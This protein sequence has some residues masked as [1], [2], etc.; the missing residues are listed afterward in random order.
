MTNWNP[1]APAT[2]GLQF[3]PDAVGADTLNAV[4]RASVIR[5]ASTVTET[6]ETAELFTPGGNPTNEGFAIIDVYPQNQGQVRTGQQTVQYLPN[7]DIQRVGWVRNP[8]NATTLLWDNINEDPAGSWTTDSIYEPS[9]SVLAQYRCNVASIG[10]SLGS[11]RVTNVAV[12]LRVFGGA[13]TVALGHTP[14][15]IVTAGQAT[16]YNAG[17]GSARLVTVNFGEFCP[18]TGAPWTQADIRAFDGDAFVQINRADLSTGY[19]SPQV[20]ALAL[21]VEMYDEKRVA[22]AV[23]RPDANDTTGFSFATV[24]TGASGWAKA[25]GTTYDLVIRQGRRDDATNT[26]DPLRMSWPWLE[27]TLPSGTGLLG[28]TMVTLHASGM[29]N[30]APALNTRRVHHLVLTGGMFTGP[31]TSVDGS[32]YA[33][34]VAVAPTATQ[35]LVP[36]AAS[37]FGAVNLQVQIPADVNSTQTLT[38][39]IKRNSDNATMGA[40]VTFD[41]GDVTRNGVEMRNGW[42]SIQRSLGAPATLASGIAY[43]VEV[44]GGSNWRVG[45]VGG[46]STRAA[47][48]YG[49]AAQYSTYLGDTGAWDMP[50]TLASVPAGISY[51]NAQVL[52]QTLAPTGATQCGSMDAVPY[53]RLNWA[54]SS[55]GGQFSAYEVE[56]YDNTSGWQ[57]IAV[58]RS[59]AVTSMDDHEARLGVASSYRVRQVRADGVASLWTGGVGHVVAEPSPPADACGLWFTTNERPDLNLAYLDVYDGGKAVR[60]FT[61]L[62]APELVMLPMYDRDYQQAFHPT[63]RRGVQFSRRVL[64]NSARAATPAS[65]RVFDPL[66]ELSVAP[67]SAVCLR[68][69]EG[70]RWYVALAVGTGE[71]RQPGD[72]AY[73]TF[74]ATEVAE[75]PSP[76][77]T[78]N[79]VL[80]WPWATLAGQFGNDGHA[81]FVGGIGQSGYSLAVVDA[82]T[83]DGSVAVNLVDPV[84]VG[85]SAVAL[86]VV[87]AQNFIYV[88]RTSAIAHEVGVVRGGVRTVLDSLFPGDERMTVTVSGS[89]SS[90]GTVVSISMGGS[91]VNSVTITD[92]TFDGATRHGIAFIGTSVP[93]SAVRWDRWEFFTPARTLGGS[94]EHVLGSWRSEGGAALP[95]STDGVDVPIVTTRQTGA[96][97]GQIQA[98]IVPAVGTRLVFRLMDATAYLYLQANPTTGVWTIGRQ[99]G[100]DAQTIG[101]MNGVPTTPEMDVVV[102][103]SGPLVRVRINGVWRAFTTGSRS[104]TLT[105]G[106]AD[107]NGT[108]HG[109]GHDYTSIETGDFTTRFL[110]WKFQSVVN[111]AAPNAVATLH[112]GAQPW[113]GK[114]V[115]AFQSLQLMS[116]TDA[117]AVM[118]GV[119]D[120]LAGVKPNELALAIEAVLSRLRAD[121]VAD[122]ISSPFFTYS[123]AW[124]TVTASDRNHGT[125]YRS[126]TAV[127][128]SFSFNIG[129][130]YNG[131]PVALL[132]IGRNAS[133]KGGT[134]AITVDGQ[135]HSTVDTQVLSGTTGNVPF[136][137][138][139]VMPPGAHTVTATVTAVA[140]AVQF[141]ALV[142]EWSNPR[143]VVANIPRVPSV[144]FTPATVTATTVTAASGMF[145][146]GELEGLTAVLYTNAGQVASSVVQSNSADTIVVSPAWAPPSGAQLYVHVSAGGDRADM[147]DGTVRRFN[148]ALA[149]VVAPFPNAVLVDVDSVVAKNTALFNGSALNAAGREAVGAAL[150]AYMVP[151]ST[152]TLWTFGTTDMAA[153]VADE[154]ASA[155]GL[156]G[157]VSDSFTSADDRGHTVADDFT[158]V[159]W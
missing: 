155:I 88:R 11:K 20:Y 45:V 123:G 137:T 84:N 122:A 112:P 107:V 91:E 119:D 74:T 103:F 140:G 154:M 14:S 13:M 47:A 6:I 94:W 147:D 63:E 90:G 54:P 67:V 138:R 18:W 30:S 36:S 156:P 127:G 1:G 110:S 115:D 33:R 158:R 32:Q 50:L 7:A 116:A 2:L 114:T 136:V 56:R 15:G 24:G 150:A 8:G 72:L 86:R 27:G 55:L 92:P 133:D 69:H 93:T 153:G 39:T 26:L 126:T 23:G 105:G 151:S 42:W 102:Q 98:T 104:L 57:T 40:P 66:R 129:A 97:D 10:F 35:V 132:W 73:M 80:G 60:D 68:D 135:P 62:D 130:A 96:T 95:W 81:A 120:V 124:S 48:G 76:I 139:L 5:L 12:K 89:A 16:G 29:L 37:T 143:V 28:G 4:N 99:W 109:I 78:A 87:D 128:A 64:V 71:L 142:A 101:T 41:R 82:G 34:L 21:S 149:Q 146:P 77:A 31:F 52:S 61:F 111:M 141:N 58:I 70:N 148:E 159:V 17:G 144:D 49:D 117:A 118:W 43:R 83:P 3:K 51:I 46:K 59:A 131:Q 113:I 125:S 157:T 75:G 25:A 79:S 106:Y 108:S 38:V 65:A 22:Y 134:V 100:G 121:M 9:R 44:T 19:V 145:Q 53:V 152:H 85:G